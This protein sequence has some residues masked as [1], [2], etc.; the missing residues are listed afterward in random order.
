[1]MEKKGFLVQFS[2]NGYVS[3]AEGQSLLEAARAGGVPSFT[4]AGARQSVLLAK[5]LY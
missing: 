5:Q 1:M 4:A 3:V 2:G